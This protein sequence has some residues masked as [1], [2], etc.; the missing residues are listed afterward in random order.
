MR[1]VI[2]GGYGVFGSRLAHLLLRDGHEVWLAGRSL[3]RAQRCAAEH[4]G[5]PLQGDIRG[6]LSPIRDVAPNAVID[7]AGPFSRSGE[8][9]CWA[10]R[11]PASCSRAATRGNTR[12]MAGFG[13]TSR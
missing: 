4:G 13:S 12:R 1:V 3:D 11:C 7:A 10:F 8:A 9:G 6:D 2:L 5:Q